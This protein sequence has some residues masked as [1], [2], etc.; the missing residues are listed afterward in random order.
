MFGNTETS[1]LQRYRSRLLPSAVV[2]TAT[3]AVI[4]WLLM[5]EGVMAVVH[6]RLELVAAGSLLLYVAYLL[7]EVPL[8]V[9]K[10]LL[11]QALH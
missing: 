3:G 9:V 1:Q 6:G 2:G 8:R 11:T 5:S 7:W 10:R 4:L